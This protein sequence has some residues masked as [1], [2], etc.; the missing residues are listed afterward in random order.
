MTIESHVAVLVA[1]TMERLRAER[2]GLLVDGTVG[3]GGHAAAWFERGGARARVLGF[4]R[5]RA[6][7]DRA[8]ARLDAA[9]DPRVE[10]VHAS[11]EEAPAVLDAR[12]LRADAILIDAG[13]ASVHF[14]DAARGFSFER[15]GPL[16][17]RFDPSAGGLT[18]EEIVRDWP[19]EELARI[20]REHGEERR[21]HAVARKIVEARRLGPIR[22]TTHLAEIVARATTGGRIHP[23]TRVFQ[24]LRIATN[25]ELGHL[26]RALE[27]LPDRLVPGGRIAVIAFHSLE[28]RIVKVA[29]RRAREEGRLTI[30]TRR[31]VRASERE[32]RENARSRSA[33]LRVAER[34]GEESGE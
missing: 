32:V 21:P 9:G 26:E 16:D 14:D 2:G 34:P 10:L 24:A 25:D 29:F 30:V 4:D 18:A 13:A 11:Y 7:L 6:M 12:G 15:D 22:T 27:A 8:A 23:A 17:M 20:F 1:E 31:A 5:D 19:E 28:S 33:Q 3:A